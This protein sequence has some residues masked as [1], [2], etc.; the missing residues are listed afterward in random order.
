MDA[1]LHLATHASIVSA[2]MLEVPPARQP[3][4]SP[5]PVWTERLQLLNYLYLKGKQEM[6][7]NSS[8]A[9]K[10]VEM[11]LRQTD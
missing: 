8:N 1:W 5:C 4:F 6:I 3:V 2:Y 7:C 10:Q 11:K 9:Q